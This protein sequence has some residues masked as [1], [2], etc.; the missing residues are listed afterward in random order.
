[1]SVLR[2]KLDVKD[3]DLNHW[4]RLFALARLTELR[5]ERL[6]V[7]PAP[8]FVAASIEAALKLEIPA[9][10]VLPKAWRRVTAPKLALF[11]ESLIERA[12]DALY[13]TNLNRQTSWDDCHEIAYSEVDHY[14]VLHPLEAWQP[15][16]ENVWK[17]FVEFARKAKVIKDG[18]LR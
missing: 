13:V 15:N 9:R 17:S 14:L 8:G 5:P 6:I 10:L 7:V 4:L 1:M 16:I 3:D 12:P 2:R 11:Y 18:R